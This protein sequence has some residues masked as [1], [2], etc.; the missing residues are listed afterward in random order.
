[1]PARPGRDKA[2][3]SGTLPAA[4][5]GRRVEQPM[6]SLAANLVLSESDRTREPPAVRP[7]PAE[8]R[9]PGRRRRPA[10]WLRRW[11][12]WLGAAAAVLV[13]A[14][15]GFAVVRGVTDKG[16]VVVRTVD[17]DVWVTL[18]QGGR[19]VASIDP[20]AQAQVKLKPGEYEV[21]LDAGGK[22]LRLTAGQI[23]LTRGGEAVV[24]VVH[25][26]KPDPP[27][28]P[29]PD[30]KPAGEP[31]PKPN[32]ASPP[33]DDPMPP[34]KPDPK[35]APPPSPPAPPATPLDTRRLPLVL[36]LDFTNAR[37]T[38]LFFAR[39]AKKKKVKMPP[40]ISQ[41][42]DGVCLTNPARAKW[43]GAGQTLPFKPGTFVCEAEGWLLN[44]GPGGWGLRFLGGPGQPFSADVQVRQAGA[45]PQVRVV[46]ITAGESAKDLL[47][48]KSVPG[49]R[50]AAER[51][52]V[53]VEVIGP[54]IRLWVNGKHAGD[55][56]YEEP[57]FAATRLQVMA[58]AGTTACFSRLRAWGS[59]VAISP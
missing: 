51:N 19:E 20:R 16:T 35:P 42:K 15:A 56:R 22:P 21:Q 3:S 23:V 37:T 6:N 24:E 34:G 29:P 46:L 48:W 43:W 28:P 14:V 39:P 55:C 9:R 31:A 2:P 38:L 17:A 53:R 52:V 50:P 5:S 47:P 44:P 12:P 30:P 57:A 7:R 8:G 54:G 4:G 58:P 13:V 41:Q 36:D 59:Q 49:L 18:R 1:V 11:G 27:P 33:P 32:P 40:Q 26:P 45:G 10:S 25:E